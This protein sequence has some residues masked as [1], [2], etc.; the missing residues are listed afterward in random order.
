MVSLLIFWM[1]NGRLMLDGGK[2]ISYSYSN[3]IYIYI[4]IYTELHTT[5]ALM[6][7]S[8]GG[9]GAVVRLYARLFHGKSKIFICRFIRRFLFFLMFFCCFS[10]QFFIRPGTDTY[11]LDQVVTMADGTARNTSLRNP[12][13][14]MENHGTTDT[15][16]NQESCANNRCMKNC[17]KTPTFLH[18]LYIIS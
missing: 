5:P 9:G 14:L 1:S 2:G 6:R 12:C 8:R 7:G 4:Y 11:P 17:S 18:T 10:G 13:F 3:N 15:V 16:S